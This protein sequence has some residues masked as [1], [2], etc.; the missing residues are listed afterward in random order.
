MQEL[1]EKSKS[2]KESA[3]KKKT[4]WKE[5]LAQLEAQVLEQ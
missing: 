4:A 5:R 1:R 3:L 2:I